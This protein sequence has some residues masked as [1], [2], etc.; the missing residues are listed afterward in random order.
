MAKK[1]KRFYDQNPGDNQLFIKYLMI[2]AAILFICFILPKQAR[3][4]FEYEKGKVWT[5]ADLISPFEFAI[6]KTPE[7][8]EKDQLEVLKTVKPVYRLNPDIELAALRAFDTDFQQGYSATRLSSNQKQADYLF[9]KNLLMEV[10]GRGI[11]EPIKRYQRFESDYNFMLLT[12]QNA[13]QRNTAEVFELG[14]AKKYI[15][16]VLNN[17]NVANPNALFKILESHLRINYLPDER[18]TKKIEKEAR[19]NISPHAGMVQKGELIIA[20]GDVINAESFQ[21]LESL[22]IAFEGDPLLR[23]NRQW[24]FLGQFFIVSLVIALLMFFLDLFRKDI[25]Q[26]HILYSHLFLYSKLHFYYHKLSLS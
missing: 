10:Y 23:A 15:L 11:V 6:Q 17:T 13:E 24:L 7:Q 25:F 16:E 18:L 14:S 22:R 26:D 20:D 3:F 21:K 5:Q 9:A 2:L 8:L 4:K 1:K 12:G 19:Q